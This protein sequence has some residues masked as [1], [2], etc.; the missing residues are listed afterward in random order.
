MK[1]TKRSSGEYK[2]VG[3][4]SDFEFTKR[5]VRF[6]RFLM[7]EMPQLTERDETFLIHTIM[8]FNE[9]HRIY[10][11]M[12]LQRVIERMDNVDTRA[13]ANDIRTSLRKLRWLG[14]NKKG[15]QSDTHL[16]E[17]GPKF[18][19]NPIFHFDKNEEGQYIFDFQ[20]HMAAN[21]EA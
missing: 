5:V 13:Y 16:K 4:Y 12:F 17:K 21:V 10:D 14:Y 2:G 3:S 15:A 18:Y 1:L 8:I 9:G 19:L 20:F 11:S 7:P 6:A